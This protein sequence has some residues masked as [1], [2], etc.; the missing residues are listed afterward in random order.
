MTRKPAIYDK[1]C[2]YVKLQPAESM[3]QMNGRQ[4]VYIFN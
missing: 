4:A 2:F 3:G 1:N